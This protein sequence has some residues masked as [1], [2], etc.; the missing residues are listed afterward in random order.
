MDL[1]NKTDVVFYRKP[2][3]IILP[4]IINKKTQTKDLTGSGFLNS[5]KLVPE[6]RTSNDDG[7]PSNDSRSSS[8]FKSSNNSLKSS[9]CMK[10]TDSR[11]LSGSTDSNG[12]VY[13]N[14]CKRCN[15]KIKLI[16]E[17]FTFSY[18]PP[19]CEK[20][21]RPEDNPYGVR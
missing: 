21:M 20:C 3:D 10:S 12:L 14:I 5:I 16:V 15:G 11:K 2:P 18:Y 7:R 19:Y 4:Q 17:C 6:S 8:D 1:S 9:I 13:G